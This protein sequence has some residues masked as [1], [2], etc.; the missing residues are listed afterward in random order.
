MRTTSAPVIAGVDTHK[1]TH[2]A[3]VIS[4]TGQHLAA[5]PFPTGEA[6]YRALEAFITSFGTVQMVGVEGTG[7]YGAGLARYLAGRGLEAREVLRPKRQVRRLHGK[8]DEIDAYLAAEA[9]LAGTAESVPKS[10]NGLVEGIRV[11]MVARRSAV[12][13]SKSARLQIRDLLVTAPEAVRAQYRGLKPRS[14]ITTLAASRPRQQQDA[15][16]SPVDFLIRRTLRD[17]ARRVLVLQREV[18]GHDSQLEELVNRANPQ[19][20]QTTGVGIV[21]ASQLLMTAGDNP[22]RLH[23][24]AAFAMLCGACPIPASSGQVTRYRLNRGGDR[25]ANSALHRIAV[26]RLHTDPRTRA[27]AARRREQGKGT[28]EILRCLKR[29]IARE[30]YRLLTNPPAV[31]NV[32]ELRPLR[33]AAGLTLTQA[34][35]DLGSS[36]AGL[37]CLERGRSTNRHTL[38]TYR[39]YLT[40]RQHAA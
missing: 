10:S 30:I 22:D 6:G 36:I 26:A 4:A 7:S 21:N 34:A 3:A 18:Q 24:E 13:A 1:D 8:S 14:L 35:T 38:N 11:V 28:K 32:A 20:L 5:A 39:D 31:I 25:Q 15:N 2:F 12:E 17:L 16:H 23:S 9:T 33:E 19:L 37:S 40:T 29:A 27:Y